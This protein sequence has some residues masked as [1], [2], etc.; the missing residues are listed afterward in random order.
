MKVY[1]DCGACFLRQSKEAIDLA[2]K[3]EELKLEIMEDVLKFLGTNYKVGASSNTIGSNMHR[4]I[5]EKSGNNDPYLKE[6]EICSEIAS[7]LEPKL[8]HI[9]KSNSSLE[10]YLKIAIVGNL[11]DFGALGLDFDPEKIISKNLNKELAINHT[12]QLEESLKSADF[13]LYLADNV[14]EINFDK[15]L[16]EKIAKDYNV[17][18][19]VALKKKPILNDACIEDVKAIN[20]DNIANLTT[21]GTDSIGIVWEDLSSEFKEDIINTDIIISKGLGNYEG[22]SE[23]KTNIDLKNA[24]GNTPVFALLC[25]KCSAISKD[26]KVNE[27]DNVLAKIN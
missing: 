14:G 3:N 17:N 10:N 2:T 22:L 8:T 12:T 24:I 6:K 18:V 21:I 5:K 26:L 1:Y 16:I 9:L 27:L 23:M 4:L 19:T 7:N 25:A 20:I 11:L 15:F 13:V